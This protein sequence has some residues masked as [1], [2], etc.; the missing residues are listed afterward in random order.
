MSEQPADNHAD[1]S[2]TQVCKFPGCTRPVVRS[3]GPGRPSEYCDLPEHTRWRAWKERQRRQ[4]HQ[5]DAETTTAS[6]EFSAARVR[7]EELLRQ[8]RLLTEQL[9]RNVRS[10]IEELNT[11]A[12]P[13][14]AE[15]QVQ[16][17]QAEQALAE[18]QQQRRQAEQA[19]ATAEAAAEDAAAA[20][21]EAARQAEAA[22]AE[23]DHALQRQQEIQ[24]QA[25]EET[26]AARNEAEVAIAAAR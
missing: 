6:G 9:S 14:A 16:A 26:E 3:N 15:A 17:A 7:A 2:T 22:R 12:D 23:R 5:A 25:R 24:Q 18:A 11:I 4:T 10:A 13:S 1:D 19:R 20:A 21:E 8:Y